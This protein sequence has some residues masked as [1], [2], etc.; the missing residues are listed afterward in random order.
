ME[1]AA[2][3]HDVVLLGHFGTVMELEFCRKNR[4]KH[5]MLEFDVLGSALFV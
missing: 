5:L 1:L 4:T 2:S 3:A